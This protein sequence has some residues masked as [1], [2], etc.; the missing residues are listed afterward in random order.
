MASLAI[1]D[2]IDL[3]ANA[4]LPFAESVDKWQVNL[5]LMILVCRQMASL[6][7]VD[8]IRL[9]TNGKPAKCWRYQAADKWQACLMLAG[10]NRLPTNGKPA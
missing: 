9:P 6:P 8:F 1:G 4:K 5:L 10:V 7:N 2:D 3:L